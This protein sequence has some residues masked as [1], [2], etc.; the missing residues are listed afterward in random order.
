MLS[1]ILLSLLR[2]GRP[3]G[4]TSGGTLREVNQ[5]RVIL[6]PLDGGCHA[7]RDPSSIPQESHV[8][9]WRTYGP[10]KDSACL[11]SFSISPP[12]ASMPVPTST[13]DT[14]APWIRSSARRCAVVMV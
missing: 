13:A 12:R 4:P 6:S 7:P 9:T 5:D 8:T 11:P 10:F 1:G 14:P 2:G 3:L